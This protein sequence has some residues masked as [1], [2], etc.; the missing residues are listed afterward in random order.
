MGMAICIA[1]CESPLQQKSIAAEIRWR[2]PGGTR[3]SGQCSSGG[4]LAALQDA[5]PEMPVVNQET[6]KQKKLPQQKVAE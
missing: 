6:A 1:N 3:C 2:V 5:C 4:T